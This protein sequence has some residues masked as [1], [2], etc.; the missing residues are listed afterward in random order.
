VIHAFGGLFLFVAAVAP[1]VVARC[2]RRSTQWAAL[3]RPSVLVGVA[4]DLLLVAGVLLG[5]NDG[6]GYVQRAFALVATAW[7]ALLAWWVIRLAA[8]P[9]PASGR[10]PA[11]SAALP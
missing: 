3:A 10:T 9:N 8:R 6:A 4:L 11:S 7:I 5:T 1:Y 2:L